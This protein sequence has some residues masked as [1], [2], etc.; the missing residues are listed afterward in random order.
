MIIGKEDAFGVPPKLIGIEEGHQA[1]CGRR[2]AGK[3]EIPLRRSE[4]R[5]RSK[6]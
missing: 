4:G 5:P 1:Y 2:V 3:V 6:E